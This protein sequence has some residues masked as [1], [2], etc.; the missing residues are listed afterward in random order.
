MFSGTKRGTPEAVVV[1]WWC[2]G[3]KVSS[4]V[5][6]KL[7]AAKGVPNKGLKEKIKTG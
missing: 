4:G 2:S 3:R 7:A 1:V 6:F 5:F